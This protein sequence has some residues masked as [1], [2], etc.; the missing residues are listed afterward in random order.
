MIHSKLMICDIIIKKLQK[1]KRIKLI[2]VNNLVIG[3][4]KGAEGTFL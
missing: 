4:L 3:E 1:I 2:R